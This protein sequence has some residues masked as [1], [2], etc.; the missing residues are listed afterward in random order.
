MSTEIYSCSTNVS[1]G[2]TDITSIF[3]AFFFQLQQHQLLVE[4]IV[5]GFWL[6]EVGT[7]MMRSTDAPKTI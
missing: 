5:L 3:C 7:I 1:L 2:V 6:L 4:T